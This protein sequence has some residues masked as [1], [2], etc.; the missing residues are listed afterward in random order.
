MLSHSV[1]VEG[2]VMFT[3]HEV[4]SCHRA[5]S[6]VDEGGSTAYG[7]GAVHATAEI[8]LMS[9]G[10]PG[11]GGCRLHTNKFLASVYL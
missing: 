10:A 5:G 9:V 11:E 6:S 1:H 7:K 8:P 4:A 3:A 2:P